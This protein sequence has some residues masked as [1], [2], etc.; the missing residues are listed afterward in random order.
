MP[1]FALVWARQTSAW[2]VRREVPRTASFKFAHSR[3]IDSLEVGDDRSTL[4]VGSSRLV[5]DR[6]RPRAVK[7]S[8][9]KHWTAFI[10][11]ADHKGRW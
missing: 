4:S 1:R 7:P 2:G 6:D 9:S 11:K 8:H 5:V 3:M 10:C